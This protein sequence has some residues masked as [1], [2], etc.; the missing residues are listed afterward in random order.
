MLSVWLLSEPYLPQLALRCKSANCRLLF[1]KGWPTWAEGGGG[2]G[3]RGGRVLNEKREGL[4]RRELGVVLG[5]W[6]RGCRC[7]EGA[8]CSIQCTR[9]CTPP[10]C[11]SHPPLWCSATLVVGVGAVQHQKPVQK[12][13]QWATRLSPSCADA[14]TAAQYRRGAANIPQCP[15]YLHPSPH[16]CIRLWPMA[17]EPN[18]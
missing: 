12:Y 14:L 16:N 4:S 1:R 6:P 10:F 7:A 5:W 13:H 15:T 17:H 9:V 3:V 11:L 8:C 2:E 18:A